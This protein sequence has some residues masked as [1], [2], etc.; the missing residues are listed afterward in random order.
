MDKSDISDIIPFPGSQVKNTAFLHIK[1]KSD[2]RDKCRGES[3][4]LSKLP[5]NSQIPIVDLEICRQID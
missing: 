2:I 5:D 1:G 3:H 4:P